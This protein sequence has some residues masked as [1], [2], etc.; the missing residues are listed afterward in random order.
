M[1]PNHKDE[2][3]RDICLD[4]TRSHS[5]LHVF[6]RQWRVEVRSRGSGSVL[7]R[8]ILA[9]HTF[10]DLET[11]RCVDS[12]ALQIGLSDPFRAIYS[13]FQVGMG[14]FPMPSP[15]QSPFSV[16]AGT[17]SMCWW[18][19]VGKTSRSQGQWTLPYLT[20]GWRGHPV[21]PGNLSWGHPGCL[22]NCGCYCW[23]CPHGKLFNWWVFFVRSLSFSWVGNYPF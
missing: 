2:R 5:C 21:I 12:Q 17:T 19:L 1:A 22:S 8:S 6:Q 14:P 20:V 7:P 3:S 13:N 10:Q 23:T 9:A 11:W 15:T 18:L 16:V 4:G